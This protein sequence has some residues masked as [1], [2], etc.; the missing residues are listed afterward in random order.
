[1]EYIYI[2]QYET[3]GLGTVWQKAYNN[4]LSARRGLGKSLG[5]ELING[6][7]FKSGDEDNVTLRHG[8]IYIQ[9]I[10]LESE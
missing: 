7:D 3:D 10:A 1:M 4:K 6:N 5:E 8:T 2:L 9:E